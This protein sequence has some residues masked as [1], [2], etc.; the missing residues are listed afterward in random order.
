MVIFFMFRFLPCLVFK[1]VL[2]VLS[3]VD[4]MC[5]VLGVWMSSAEM[6]ICGNSNEVG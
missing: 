6:H 2:E 1:F 5:L 4:V 3:K